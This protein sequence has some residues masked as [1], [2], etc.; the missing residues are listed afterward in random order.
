MNELLKGSNCPERSTRTRSSSAWRTPVWRR[1]L[2]R[3]G[4]RRPGGLCRWGCGRWR[5]GCCG[6]DVGVLGILDFVLSRWLRAAGLGEATASFMWLSRCSFPCEIKGKN[7]WGRCNIKRKR[8]GQEGGIGTV[9]AHRNLPRTATVLMNSGDKNCQPGGAQI[10]S[11]W[12]QKQRGLWGIYRWIFRG[13]GGTES[14]GIGRFSWLPFGTEFVPDMN[15][16]A[17]GWR[18]FAG[19]SYQQK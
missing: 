3:G 5:R 18:W 8:K 17:G 9:L 1:R 16:Q 15:Q 11:F 19:P 10:Q 7:N 4:G 12:R 6:E 14:N 2:G 13:K